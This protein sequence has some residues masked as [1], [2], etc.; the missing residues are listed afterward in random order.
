M[1]IL[2]TSDWHV[3]KVLKGQSRA[4]EHKQVLAAVIEVARVERPD[5]VI[6]AGDL[7]DTAAPTSEATRLVT[8]ALTALR[9]TGADVVAIGGN[10]DNGP[11]LDA[12]RPWA[13]A[14]GITLRG[15]VLADPDEHVVDGVTAG[16]ERW[17]LA[18]LPFLSQRY[19]VRAVEMYELTAAE[20]TQT[21][22]DHLGRVLDRLTEG[23]D[24]PDR[25]HLV[26]AHLTVVG[27]STG[28][29]ERDAHTVLGYA[30]PASVFPGTAHY[31]ALGHLH[32]S[33]RVVGPCPVR[34]SGS[35]LAVDFGEQENVPSVTVVEVTATTAARVREVPIAAAVPLR[36]VRGTLAQ[37]AEAPPPEGLLRVFVSEQPRAG[38]R[39]EVQELL[40]HALEIRI[41]PQL[42]P[43]PGSATRTAQRS[44]RSP[45][46]LFADYLGSRG[47]A[48]DEVRALFDELFEEVD[49]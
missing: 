39:E 49:R 33:Q 34:Y 29:G 5:L 2:H 1:K 43:A 10:H 45:R 25:V 37:L 16:G 17:R 15:S 40:P 38:L 30:V 12:L 46:D 8:R 47:H 14:A 3:G 42:L 9:R 32:R 48:D 44:G 13:E 7:Y 36:T 21:Y 6:V 18:A 28:G 20:A 27:A 23:F 19:A 26:T 31:V 41:D 35:P 11:A 22:A 4:E 24:E